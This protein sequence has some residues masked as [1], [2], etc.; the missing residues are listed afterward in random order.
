MRADA[1]WLV[2]LLAASCLA[3]LREGV[4][5]PDAARFSIR[6]I[7]LGMPWSEVV[8]RLG[9]PEMASLDITWKGSVDVVR[10]GEDMSIAGPELELDGRAFAPRGELLSTLEGSLGPRYEAEWGWT[11]PGGRLAFLPELRF[12]ENDTR[13]ACVQSFRLASGRLTDDGFYQAAYAGA[14]DRA[15][16][17]SQAED[18]THSR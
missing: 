2:A 12:C 13:P 7:S 3:S 18:P 4:A 5:P 11:L 16:S 10:C 14:M 9:K 1:V 15:A 8:K 6:G 17:R